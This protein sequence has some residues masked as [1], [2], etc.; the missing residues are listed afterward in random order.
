MCVEKGEEM[1]Y[2]EAL[3]VSMAHLTQV[4]LQRTHPS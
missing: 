4:H 1:A 3:C 2:D